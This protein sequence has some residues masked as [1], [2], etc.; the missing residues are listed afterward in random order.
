[1]FNFIFVSET[2]SIWDTL[3]FDNCTDDSKSSLWYVF[4]NTVSTP[5]FDSTGMFVERTQTGNGYLFVGQSNET[6]KPFALDFAIEFDV[7]EKTG[8]VRCLPDTNTFDS[9][10]NLSANDHIKIEY[11]TDKQIVTRNNGTPVETAHTNSGS[12]KAQFQFVGVGSIKL[13]NVKVYSI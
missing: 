6:D 10:N 5:S 1:M 9:V 4:R 8:D 2:Y 7:V 3:F 13:K 12:L 11:Y